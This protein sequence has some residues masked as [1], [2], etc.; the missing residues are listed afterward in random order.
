MARADRVAEEDVRETA[1]PMSRSGA[2]VILSSTSSRLDAEALHV[3]L[4]GAFDAAGM[5]YRVFEVPDGGDARPAIRREVGRALAEGIERVIAVGGDGTVAMAGDALARIAGPEGGALLG[6]VP[7]GT[8]NVLAGEL[9]ITGSLEE[10]VAA[11]VAEDGPTLTLDAIQVGDRFCFTQVGVGPD[12]LMIRDTSRQ[13]QSRHGRLAYMATFLRRFRQPARRFR[14]ELDGSL[15]EARAWQIIVANAGSLGA[16]PF[17]WGPGID[18]TDAIMN[19]CVFDARGA[20]DYARLLWRFIFGR[21]RRDA[22]TRYFRIRD[23]VVIASDRPVL[24]QGDGEILGKT[25][26]TVTLKPGAVRVLVHREVATS[27][28]SAAPPPPTAANPG[29]TGESVAKDVETMLATEHSR[30][31]VLQGWLR[32]PVAALEALDAAIFLRVNALSYRL[33]DR[34][35][36]TISSTMRYGEGWAFVLFVMILVDFRAGLRTAVAAGPVIGLTML[37]VNFPLKRFF[38]RRR[39][40]IAFVKARVFGTRPKDFSFP[41]GHAAAGFAGAF[42]LSSH[43]PALSPFFY[44]LAVVVSLSRVYLGVHYPSDVAFGGLLG[45]LIA[46]T[47]RYLLHSLFPWIG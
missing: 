26:V 47:Y 20:R 33:A 39:P 7:T 46:A 4:E 36:W 38:R 43:A 10:A 30:T 40:F 19:L 35:A 11:T 16:P 5:T 37:T 13:S 32:H 18:P 31:W 9:G 23:R 42:I 12:A 6:I 8:A 3:A 41:S 22:S 29:G 1:E 27:E 24:V 25:P 28:E 45:V 2:L 17:T 44:T 34:A 15:L 14:L 21:H